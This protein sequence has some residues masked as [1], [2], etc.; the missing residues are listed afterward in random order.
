MQQNLQII[1]IHKSDSMY[2][3]DDH[4]N[5]CPTKKTAVLEQC[6]HKATIRSHIVF[7]QQQHL[8]P[9]K[10]ENNFKKEKR[11]EEDMLFL[12]EVLEGRDETT[13]L[14]I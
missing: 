8:L 6:T 2:T 12:E 14:S 4:I 7:S 5:Y 13:R 11:Q 1:G 10:K 3:Q 9:R